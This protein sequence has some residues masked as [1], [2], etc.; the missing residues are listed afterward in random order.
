MKMMLPTLFKRTATNAIQEWNIYAEQ[1]GYTVE[2]G[3][4]DGA[5]QSTFMPVEPKNV[6]R[7][8]ET[9]LSQQIQL[10]MKSK[11]L[12]QQDKGYRE[13][14]D[15][16]DD[17]KTYMPMLAKSFDDMGHKIEYPC[18][19]QP[20]LD[21]IRCLAYTDNGSVVLLS[22]KGK[23]FDV[24]TTLKQVISGIRLP[25]RVILDGELFTKDVKFQ[26][27]I[28][29]VKRDKK[30]ADTDKI[31]YHIYDCIMLDAPKADF[32]TRNLFL[33]DLFKV[34]GFNKHLKMVATARANSPSDIMKWHKQFT[35]EG[36]EGA[37]ARNYSGLYEQNRRSPNLQKVKTFK[38]EEFEIVGAKECTGKFSGMCTF[39]CVT[40]SGAEFEVMPEGTEQERKDYWTK[41][42]ELIGKM[43][44]VRFFEWTTSNP[45]VP[46]FPT[47]IRIREEDD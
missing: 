41:H 46:R 17:A 13:S 18:A 3:Q 28:S 11:W 2:W 26:S 27:I 19:I 9:T 34:I 38:D 36:Y 6:G 43:L 42:K 37:M 30:N 14:I 7:A 24:L 47:G 12:S 33:Q 45:P 5:K 44:N 39:V 25:K 31:Q 32:K 29:A 15:D 10:E 23:T 40:K 8:N 21:G 35:S 16:I 4:V 1:H 22:R 20:K